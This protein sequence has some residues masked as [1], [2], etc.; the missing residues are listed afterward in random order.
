MKA[1][2]EKRMEKQLIENSISLWLRVRLYSVG[3][4]WLQFH[5][6]WRGAFFQLNL[7][8]L[9]PALSTAYP[10]EEVPMAMIGCKPLWSSQIRDGVEDTRRGL[11][12]AGFYNLT[13]AV[14]G[15]RKTI[16][17]DHRPQIDSAALEFFEE[18]LIGQLE[19]RRFVTVF[20]S[21][22]TLSI[23]ICVASKTY[24]RPHLAS[25][26]ASISICIFL[27]RSCGGLSEEW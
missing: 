9:Y 8:K 22:L 11:P 23:V 16:M 14:H 26:R 1:C 25:Y 13:R 19:A 24:F 17:E 7:I 2:R 18:T 3:F 15:Q 6:S 5:D 21:P 27:I 20:D 10:Q 12:S 4:I